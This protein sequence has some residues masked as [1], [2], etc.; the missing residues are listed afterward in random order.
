MI[1]TTDAVVLRTLKYRESSTI[2]AL[3]T[4][5]RGKVSVLAKGARRR[6]NAMAASL[7]PL[8]ILR[9]VIYVRGTR[10]LQTLTQADILEPY[11]SL[12]NDLPRLAAGMAVVELVHLATHPDEPNAP[13]FDLLANV[14]GHISR[15]TK[16]PVNALYYFEIHFLEALGLRP[17][18]DSCSRCGEDAAVGEAA[19]QE[20]EMTLGQ[21]GIL[22]ARCS[23][24]GSGSR[25]ISPAALQILRRFQRLS[26]PDGA[27]AV[28]MLRRV[29]DEVHE[30][31]R[32]L[33]HQHIPEMRSLKSERVFA[34]ILSNSGG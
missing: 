23:T 14:L 21:G 5:S 1:V 31:L 2:A 10:E 11:G 9:S 34:S 17:R 7:A 16:P 32:W 26:R 12:V 13:L 15:A 27:E 4:R 30:S 22:C 24:W 8:N 25:P 3:Y 19:A 20:G 33:M 18:L 29:R 6:N 28:M